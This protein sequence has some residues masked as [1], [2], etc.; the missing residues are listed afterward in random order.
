MNSIIIAEPDLFCTTAD[1]SDLSALGALMPDGLG[2]VIPTVD[3]INI[4]HRLARNKANEAVQHAVNCGLM[5][6]QV[7]ASKQHGQWLPWLDGE[8]EAGR[9]AVKDRQVRSY[10]QLASNWQRDANLL[11]APSI[12]QALELFSDKPDATEQPDLLIE[13]EAERAARIAAEQEAAAERADK[14]DSAMARCKAEEKISEE[15]RRTR[16]FQIESNERRKK[17]IDLEMEI[18]T[19]KTAAPIVQ[20]IEVIPADYETAKA[21]AAKRIAELEAVNQSWVDSDK[22]ARKLIEVHKREKVIQQ[23][24]L[25]MICRTAALLIDLEHTDAR[26]TRK[27]WLEL[28]EMHSEAA[29]AIK[30]AFGCVWEI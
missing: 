24:R 16:E 21:Q 9:L 11:E 14:L 27:R 19:L 4:E 26:E 6:L 12:R 18:D 7:K 13:L 29:L 30:I 17:I 5:L 23:A 25:D 28:A 2:V 15:A 3:M 10:M 22:D 20:T 1:Q 8:I